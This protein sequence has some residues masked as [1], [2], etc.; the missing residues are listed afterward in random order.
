MRLTLSIWGLL[1]TWV[2]H[3]AEEWFAVA[4]FVHRRAMRAGRTVS[5]RKIE[6]HERTAIAVMGVIVAAATWDGHRTGGA[7]P[8]FR[9]ALAGFG[10]HGVGHLAM[11]AVMRG[12]TPGVAT[13]P[14]LVIPYAVAAWR[15]L[16]RSGARPATRT[17]VAWAPA[18]VAGSLGISH[19]V[20]YLVAARVR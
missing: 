6:V 3:D 15:E 7:S 12:Y 5:I 2:V 9:S 1:G 4:P 16:E 14:T 19:L 8:I 20:G 10:M 18:M 17:S 13:A 11:S